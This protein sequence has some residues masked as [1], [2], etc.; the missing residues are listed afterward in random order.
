MKKKIFYL[1]GFIVVFTI[2]YLLKCFY[3]HKQIEELNHIHILSIIDNAL[4]PFG[5]FLLLKFFSSTTWKIKTFVIVYAIIMT[6]ELSLGYFYGNGHFD[7]NYL[8][9]SLL[10]V[11]CVFILDYISG[12]TQC[13]KQQEQTV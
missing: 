3:D 9:G 1:V 11:V 7:Y 8:I 2:N 10:G 4:S 13:D 6:L 5:L 12:K